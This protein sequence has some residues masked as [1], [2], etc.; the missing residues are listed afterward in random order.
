M[1]FEHAP[2]PVKAVQDVR[3]VGPGT[4]EI[5]I[6]VVPARTPVITKGVDPDPAANDV[7]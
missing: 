2:L 6:E 1:G 5:V 7:E 4:K 3:E